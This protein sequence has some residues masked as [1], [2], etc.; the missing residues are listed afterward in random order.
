VLV[1]VWDAAG[2]TDV[3]RATGAVAGNRLRA[4]EL[5]IPGL[6]FGTLFLKLPRYCQLRFQNPEQRTVACRQGSSICTLCISLQIS[7][8]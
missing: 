4:H 6:A 2:V 8:D 7:C 5:S 3:D 1:P